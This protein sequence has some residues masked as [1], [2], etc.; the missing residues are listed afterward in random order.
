MK[1]K[2]EKKRGEIKGE[3]K[4]IKMAIKNHIEDEIKGDIPY[5]LDKLPKIK[6]FFEI[7]CDLLNGKN[8]ES[9]IIEKLA[10]TDLDEFTE[11]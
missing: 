9:L 8:N 1:L 11:W 3:I 2:I 6:E 5:T 10:E 7:H 4:L